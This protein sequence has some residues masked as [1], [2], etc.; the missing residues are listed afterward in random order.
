MNRILKKSALLLVLVL[1]VT[2]LFACGDAK[3]KDP[4]DSE[5]KLKV[6]L[7]LPGKKDD[8]SFN[9]AMFVALDNYAS[10]NSDK[11][12]LHVVENAYEENAPHKLCAYIYELANA[13]NGFYHN[14]KILAEENE[15]TQKSYIAILVLTK[16]I[17]ETCIDI[18]GFEAPERM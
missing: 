18:L 16:A 8:V 15:K 11:V 4:D 6:A 1:L 13:F 5:G 10:A 3:E 9:Q 7:V 2:S 12:D 14:T 17:L